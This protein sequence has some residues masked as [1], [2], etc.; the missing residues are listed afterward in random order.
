M[1]LYDGYCY[2]AITDVVSS[3]VSA[4]VEYTANYIVWRTI[5]LNSTGNVLSLQLNKIDYSGVIQA[6]VQTTQLLPSCSQVGPYPTSPYL[7]E[8]AD[9]LTLSWAVVLVWAIAWGIKYIRRAL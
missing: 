4:P 8:T 2:N 1:V 6:P 3:A 5:K 7:F 9:A